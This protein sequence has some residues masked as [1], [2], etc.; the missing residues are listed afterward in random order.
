MRRMRSP[1]ASFTTGA[2]RN[3]AP[4]SKMFRQA[5]EPSSLSLL[6]IAA[7][8]LRT[9]IGMDESTRR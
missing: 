4:V 9:L 5:W 1:I 3:K 2:T 7:W 8:C 6:C